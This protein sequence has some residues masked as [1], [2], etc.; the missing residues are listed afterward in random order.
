VDKKITKNKKHQAR[1]M[2]Q[3]SRK[4]IYCSCSFREELMSLA[5][6]GI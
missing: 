2:V 4:S 1:K 5:S 3:R 6:T